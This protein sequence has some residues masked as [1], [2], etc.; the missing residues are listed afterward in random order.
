M[1]VLT[2]KRVRPIADHQGDSRLTYGQHI[3]QYDTNKNY[4]GSGKRRGEQFRAGF[5]IMCGAEAAGKRCA[6]IVGR[7]TV[8]QLMQFS[9]AA[10][11][12]KFGHR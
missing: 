5:E 12:D 9:E 2:C 11:C 7:V 8:C 10:F 3:G 1:F 6:R 4:S